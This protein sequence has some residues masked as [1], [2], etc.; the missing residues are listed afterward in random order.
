M[1]LLAPEDPY[2]GT[3]FAINLVVCVAL[4]VAAYA[5]ATLRPAIRSIPM[6]PWRMAS[7]HVLWGERLVSRTANRAGA[8]LILAG[9]AAIL[10]AALS[11]WPLHGVNLLLFTGFL[12]YLTGRS[13]IF[14]TV[15]S[16][17]T[18]LTF[19]TREFPLAEIVAAE[20]AHISPRAWM[21]V[22]SRAADPVIA[23]APGPAVRLRLTGDRTAL[24]ATSDPDHV[25]ALINRLLNPP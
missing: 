15:R 21:L 5:L 20:P 17:V 24:I 11:P 18:T 10:A 19:T 12:L 2:F 4:S 8:A 9:F 23:P 16:V 1:T 3:P 7:G 6:E 13:R 22:A 25:A 14:V